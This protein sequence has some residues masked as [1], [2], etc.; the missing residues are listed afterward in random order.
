VPWRYV[1]GIALSFAAAL[2]ILTSATAYLA[3][4]YAM[5]H[6]DT[7]VQEAVEDRDAQLARQ[8]AAIDEYRRHQCTVVSAIPPPWTPE[9]DRLYRVVLRCPELTGVPAPLPSRAGR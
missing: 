3:A 8:Q 2:V 7:Q 6:T 1:L 9:L 4:A 5:E